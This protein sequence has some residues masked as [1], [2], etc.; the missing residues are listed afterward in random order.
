M[1]SGLIFHGPPGTG[2]TLLAKALA[3]E[4][5]VP[6]YSVSGSDFVEMF[7]GRGAARVRELFADARGRGRVIF[8]DEFDALGKKRGGGA[9]GGNDEREQTLE[10][11]P[12]RDGRLHATTA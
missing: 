10:P 11:A 1:P 3:G 2:K 5:E 12:R 8:F 6:F 4:A 9:H 7:V